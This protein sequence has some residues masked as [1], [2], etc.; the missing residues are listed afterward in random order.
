MNYLP[1]ILIGFL[2]MNK[3]GG[4]SG[5]LSNLDL[6]SLAP[7]L[8]LTGLDENALEGIKALSTSGGDIKS[9]LPLLV[10]TFNQPAKNPSPSQVET[11][12]HLN[13]I[14]DIASAEIIST[15]GN[16]FEN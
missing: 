15:L 10:K 6:E 13:P 9:L 14:K 1:L 12:N 4:L 3:S 2:L 16:Y 7:L 5:L 8:S 11:P